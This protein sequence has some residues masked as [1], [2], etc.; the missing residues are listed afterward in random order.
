MICAHEQE[1]A[2][3]RMCEPANVHAC[4]SAWACATYV[5]DSA[6]LSYDQAWVRGENGPCGLICVHV[7]TC[8]HKCMTGLWV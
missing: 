6:G 5:D 3:V 1:C 8:M 4:E 2:Q 7:M